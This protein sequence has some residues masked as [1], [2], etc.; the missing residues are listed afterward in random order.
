MS[1]VLVAAVAKQESGFNPAAHSGAGADG[2]MQF[3]PGT[4]STYNVNT[5][6]AA[7]SIDGGA[8]FLRALLERYNDNVDFALAAYN[9]GTNAVDKYH[10]VPPYRETQN[11][12]RLIKAMIGG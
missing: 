5:S 9:A 8:Q 4:A 2:L 12:V 7:S 3:M 10:G 11:Y 1:P 6:D